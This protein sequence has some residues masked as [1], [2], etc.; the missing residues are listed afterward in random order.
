M[1]SI[2]DMIN[3]IVNQDYTKAQNTFADIMGD[4]ISDALDQE[5]VA[6]AQNMYSEEEYEEAEEEL[7]DELELTDDDYENAAEE[8]END[9][10]Y[11]EYEED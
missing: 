6:I 11:E 5:K 1:S 9:E 2:E 7:D 3:N 10:E 4:K 8:L